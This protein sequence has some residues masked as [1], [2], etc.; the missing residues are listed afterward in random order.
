MTLKTQANGGQV[1]NANGYD[2]LFFSNSSLTTRLKWETERYIA[3]TGEVIYWV[4]VPTLSSTVDTNIYMAYGNSSITTDQST[5]TE[6]WDTNYKG[7]WHLPNGT[8]LTASDSTTN[9]YTGTLVNSPTATTGIVDGAG[10]FVSSTPSYVN[11]GNNIGNY[12]TGD[13]TL[14]AWVYRSVNSFGWLFTKTGGGAGNY[15]QPFD[16]NFTNVSGGKFSIVQG[17]TS[18]NYDTWD[19]TSSVP[20]GSWF[21]IAAWISNSGTPSRSAKFF[22]NGV[23]DI[24]VNSVSSTFTPTNG[25][26][27]AML[28][29]RMDNSGFD[30]FIDEMRVSNSIRSDGWIATNYNNQSSP[31]TFYAISF[32]GIQ[33]QSDLGY[34]LIG[35]SSTIIAFDNYYGCRFVASQS[36]TITSMSAYLSSTGIGSVTFGIYAD[37][38]GAP[39]SLLATSTT[40]GSFTTSPAWTSG[41]ISYAITAGTAYWL[42]IFGDDNT[43]YYYDDGSINQLFVSGA[44]KVYPSFD[45]TATTSGGYENRKIS[46]YATFTPS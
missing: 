27:N 7:I 23:A 8:T 40:T 33:V 19:S 17:D 39:G 18:N 25:T 35:G 5:P 15:P 20:T 43:F 4:K 2:I 32:P 6:V 12:L 26:G 41:N 30:G 9:A 45:S 28:A 34:T 21:H 1:A 38:S 24:A 14:E 46:I 16:S 11:F 29:N 31:S 36:G 37:S 10:S 42:S 22:I 44:G 3:T 13:V